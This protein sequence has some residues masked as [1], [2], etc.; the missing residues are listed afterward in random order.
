MKRICLLSRMVF[1]VLLAFLGLAQ[2][3][4]AQQHP[5]EVEA[6]QMLRELVSYRTAKG[7]GEVPRLAAY[8]EKQ[9]LAAGFEGEDI[10]I[11]PMEPDTASMVVRYRGDGSG[12]RPIL[13]LAHM[14]IVD[15]HLSD[16]NYDPFTLLEKDGY[17]Y[18]RGVSDNKAG[19]ATL[20][21]TFIRL[22]REDYQPSR[23]LVLAFTG[24]EEDEMDNIR[25][26]VA[27]HRD[28]VD[29]EFA[30]NADA[31]GGQ[32][33]DM[34]KPSYFVIQAG[35]KTEINFDLT[36]RNKGGHSSE[37]RKDNAI[38]EL[39]EAIRKIQNHRFP[40][41]YND[42]T[43][44]YFREAADLRSGA[45]A[46]AMREFAENPGDSDAVAVMDDYPELAKILR[47]TCVPTMLKA[48]HGLSA[49]PQSASANINCRVFP[50]IS[51]TEMWATLVEI[52]AN[53]GAE[54]SVVGKPSAGP[55]LPLL[56]HVER[57][58]T[59]VVHSF[60]PGLKVM[61][62]MAPYATDGKETRIAGIPTYGVAGVFFGMDGNNEHG[63]DERLRK[64]TYL[65]S[66]EYWYRV[67]KT[68]AGD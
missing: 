56:P 67:I 50:G 1:P 30:L 44:N 53:D 31:G 8:L 28:L 37:P 18:G 5:H 17:F 6:V 52:V 13:F 57:Q 68:F 32:Y 20:I 65:D 39:V 2:H 19:I 12:G 42:V 25:E 55:D 3:G 64:D 9:L 36:V 49:L 24:D 47:T 16:W 45:V 48:G 62:Y 34:G 66:L 38:Y 15:A 63:L 60:Y 23:D 7:Y 33:D 35:E 21:N 61:N 26:L 22:K 46:T 43:R 27:E 40:V 51:V 10:H 29:A 11:L 58:L 4:Y 14:D 54:I 41:K 59:E